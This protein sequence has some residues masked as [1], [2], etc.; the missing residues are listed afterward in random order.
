VPVL[1]VSGYAPAQ[2]AVD[3][4]AHVLAK[5]FSSKELLSRVRDVLD[6]VAVAVASGATP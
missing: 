6:G 5:P 4:G 2:V 3:L 1:F